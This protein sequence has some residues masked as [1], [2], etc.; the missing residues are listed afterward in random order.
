MKTNIFSGGEIQST[1][2]YD[3]KQ[4]LALFF[5]KIFSNTPLT[6][7]FQKMDIE[8]GA[9]HAGVKV[10]QLGAVDAV[11]VGAKPPCHLADDAELALTW[12]RLGAVTIGAKLGAIVIYY[13]N[14]LLNFCY[15]L[16]IE[17]FKILP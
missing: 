14:M 6:E 7:K 13:N 9:I 3:Y 2:K 17:K 4:T 12:Q 8:L 1:I 15:D 16:D 11:D 5:R 10:T